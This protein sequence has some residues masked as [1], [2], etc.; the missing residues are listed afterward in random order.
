M[1]VA[2]SQLLQLHE[3]RAIPYRTLQESSRLCQED[4]V[5]TDI[6]DDVQA[7]LAFGPP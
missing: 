3:Q 6:V 4:P 2:T 5:I 7:L 1:D